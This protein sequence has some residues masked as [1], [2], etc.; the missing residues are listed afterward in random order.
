[1]KCIFITCGESTEDNKKTYHECAFPKNKIL[2]DAKIHS[3]FNCADYELHAQILKKKN[4]HKKNQH[5]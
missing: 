1:M 5:R 3:I 2:L 4:T